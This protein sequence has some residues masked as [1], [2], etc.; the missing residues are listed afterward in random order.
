M[1]YAEYKEILDKAL[2]DYV[3]NGGSVYYIGNAMKEYFFEYNGLISADKQDR[4]NNKA[5]QA[6]LEK[7]PLPEGIRLTQCVIHE[8]R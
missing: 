2:A 7:K 3:N 4:L 8:R 1:E 6:M 5:I